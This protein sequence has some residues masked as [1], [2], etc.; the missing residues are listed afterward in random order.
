MITGQTWTLLRNAVTSQDSYGNDVL[1]TTST[2]VP[3]CVFQPGQSSEATQGADQ[4]T[5]DARLF[6]PQGVTISP[7]D[8]VQAPP[9]LGS[10]IFDVQ[11]DL[12]NWLSPFTQVPGYQMARLRRIIGGSAH[13]VS[14]G[15][16]G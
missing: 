16:G 1:T 14:S 3:G 13:A 7:L 8:Q 11:G 4:V 12:S 2:P 5:Y 9:E 10:D 15:G 6:Y